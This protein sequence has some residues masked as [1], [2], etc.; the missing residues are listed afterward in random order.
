MLYIIYCIICS[1]YLLNIN[2]LLSQLSIFLNEIIKYKVFD[3]HRLK[4]TS[5]CVAINVPNSSYFLYLQNTRIWYMSFDIRPQLGH[6]WAGPQLGHSWA[7]T[8]PSVMSP[9]GVLSLTLLLV[10]G[11]GPAPGPA[12]GPVPGPVPGPAPGPAPGPGLR[13]SSWSSSWSRA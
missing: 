10:Q 7:E 4:C 11:L 1:I 13:A 5:K 8:D 3:K 6:S 2:K 12:P 9:N